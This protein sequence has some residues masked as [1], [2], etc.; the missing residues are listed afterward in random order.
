MRLPMLLD[1]LAPEYQL[2]VIAD[3][4][5][6]L[7]CFRRELISRCCAFF[8]LFLT[9][10]SLSI[11]CCSSAALQLDWPVILPFFSLWCFLSLLSLLLRN[12]V[13]NRVFAVLVLHLCARS[14]GFLQPQAWARTFEPSSLACFQVRQTAFCALTPAQT[15][16]A[17]LQGP[18]LPGV[19]VMA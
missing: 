1:F 8:M 10:L 19:L 9:L 5:A 13:L 4:C 7:A 15:L 18:C 2:P 12:A 11:E 6:F 16:N 3:P 17:I 14:L